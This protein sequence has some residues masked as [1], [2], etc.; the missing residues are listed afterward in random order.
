VTRRVTDELFPG[1][2]LLIA[3]VTRGVALSAADA[4]A[5]VEEMASWPVPVRL[6]RSSTIEGVFGDDWSDPGMDVYDE[7]EAAR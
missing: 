6:V 5:L 2:W 7:P 1:D 4:R 3:A